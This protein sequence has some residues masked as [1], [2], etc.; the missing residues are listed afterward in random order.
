MSETAAHRVCLRAL[1]GMPL[2]T[3]DPVLTAEVTGRKV[4]TESQRSGPLREARWMPTSPDEAGTA[5]ELG[6]MSSL[7]TLRLGALRT[8]TRSIRS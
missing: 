2:A 4:T 6:S 1:P 5:F 3:D 8:A 7:L